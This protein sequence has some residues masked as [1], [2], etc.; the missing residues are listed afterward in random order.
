MRDTGVVSPCTGAA[1]TGPRPRPAV[2]EGWARLSSPS[3]F[4]CHLRT[5]LSAGLSFFS[6]NDGRTALRVFLMHRV[7]LDPWDQPQGMQREAQQERVL[8]SWVRW[9]WEERGP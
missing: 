8:V 5:G 6:E 4:L 3:C 7:S 9:K 1:C 2:S